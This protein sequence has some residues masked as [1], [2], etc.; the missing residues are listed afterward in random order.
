MKRFLSLIIS[1]AL[2]FGVVVAIPSSAT[3]SSVEDGVLDLLSELSIMSGDPD[4]N[5]RL[6]DY[7]SRAEFTKIAVASSSYKN[8]VATNLAISPFPDVTYKHWA[9]PYVRV[10]VTGGIVS[11][12]PDATFKPDDTVLY[13]EAITML[14]RV[15]GYTDSDFGASWPSGQIGLANNLDMTDNVNCSAGDIM[16][17]RQVAQ[18]V[19]NTLKTKQKGQQNALLSLFDATVYKDT[20]LVASSGEDSSIASDEVFTS[21]GTYKIDSNFDLS[22]IG[23]N[24]DAIVKDSSKLIAFVPDSSSRATQEYIVYSVLAD[25]VMAYKNGTVTQIKIDDSTSAYKGKSQLTFG[26]L[27]SQLEFGDRLIVAI[28]ETGGVDYV[29]YGKGDVLGPVT[30]VGGTWKSTWGVDDSVSVTRGGSAATSSDI[31]NYD[32][33]Y[34]LKDLNMVL[35]YTN[36]VTGIYEKATPNRDMPTSITVSGTEYE[37]EG[38]A[39]FNKVYSGGTFEYGDTITLLLGRGGKVADVITPSASSDGVVG[40]LTNTGTKQYSVGDINTYTNYSVT[41]VQPDGTSYDYVT[42]R[43]YSEMVN[44]VVKLSFSDGYARISRVNKSSGISGTVNWDSKKI[45]STK[46]SSQVQILD[47]GTTD[48]TDQAMYA[49][50]YGQRIDEVTLSS[51]SVLFA[52]KN[53]SGEITKLILNSVTND[54]SNFGLITSA[55]VTSGNGLSAGSS[56]YSYIINGNRYS[57]SKSGSFSVSRGSAAMICGNLNNPDSIIPIT[58][59]SDKITSITADKLIAGNLTHKISDKV[60]VYTRKYSTSYEYSMISI[61]DLINNKDD[62]TISAYYDKTAKSGGRVRLILATEK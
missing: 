18:L 15:L 26:A 8:S 34:Y 23:M 48:I 10:G 21:N 4:G 46:L 57:I 54:S 11:G 59:I 47:V 52:E 53:S 19:Y 12:Y 42:D 33:L 55:E 44:S 6:D 41:I 31:Q 60:Q 40:Y 9:A 25:K 58:Y 28:S 2:I 38:S 62:Y 45:G 20:T 32:V 24:G 49:K 50:V 13:E 43:D 51:D 7:V 37:L 1:A 56:K 36:K 35:A 22:K 39:A 27:K 5:L 16:S 14:L 30:S 17:R 61:E 29:T 3:A